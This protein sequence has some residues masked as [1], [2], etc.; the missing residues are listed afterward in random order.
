MSIIYF[1]VSVFIYFNMIFFRVV[2][3]LMNGYKA[4]GHSYDVWVKPIKAGSKFFQINLRIVHILFDFV[5]PLAW[6]FFSIC[7][8]GYTSS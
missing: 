5:Q 8:I 6:Y 4:S 3:L 7:E 1:R 2:Y